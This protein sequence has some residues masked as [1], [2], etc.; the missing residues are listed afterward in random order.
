MDFEV[1][2]R[3]EIES[4]LHYD[5]IVNNRSHI[6]ISIN[7]D[8]NYAC[9]SSNKC[10][11]DILRL[12]FDDIDEHFEEEY[13][14]FS[15]NQAQQILE[16]IFKYL[17]EIDLIIIHCHAGISRSAGVGCALSYI[18]NQNDDDLVKKK[19]CFNRF[20]YRTILNEYFDN[21]NKYPKIGV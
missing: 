7:E 3:R 14:L 15:I 6:V 5:K 11:C 18:I 13:N 8:S 12:I 19:P 1:V 9:I 10:C 20:V 2:S 17:N 21:V 4:N 16:F